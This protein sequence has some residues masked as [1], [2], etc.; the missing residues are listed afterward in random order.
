MYIPVEHE[1]IP[2]V[3]IDNFLPRDYVTRL[4]EDF[5]KLKPHF[6][7]PVWHGG[8]NDVNFA[9]NPDEPLSPRCTGQD[10]WLPFDK[11]QSEK[12]KDVGYYVSNLNKYIFHQ[13][14]LDFLAHAKSEELTS[15]AK[16]GYLY[17]YHIINYGDGG[18]YNWHRDLLVSGMTW[19]DVEVNKQN[20]FTFALTLIKDPS[21]MKGGEQYFMYKNHTYRLPLTSNQLVIFPSTVFHACSEIT[22][23][24]DLEWENKRF[25]IQAWLCHR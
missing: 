22:A 19:S 6:G 18:Y 14:I 11:D 10:I 15:Y 3:V 12:N 20:A 8:H 7:I 2:L 5:I 1:H 4:Y 23:P 25:N 9:Y 16:F 21:V 17:K 24:K 13:G